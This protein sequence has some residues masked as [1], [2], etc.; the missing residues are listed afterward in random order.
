[1]EEMVHWHGMDFM[2]LQDSFSTMSLRISR[3]GDS[4]L[5]QH[6]EGQEVQVMP[7]PVD[8]VNTGQ[9]VQETVQSVDSQN[10]E[11]E[12]Q[13]QVMVQSN[14]PPTVEP[15]E[16]AQP[17]DVSNPVIKAAENSIDTSAKQP[18]KIGWIKRITTGILAALGIK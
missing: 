12:M 8:S 15:K 3:A 1:M 7:Q 5:N 4:W 11:Q 16:T 18:D 10:I 17:V 14:S 6:N 13:M 2:F 9:E